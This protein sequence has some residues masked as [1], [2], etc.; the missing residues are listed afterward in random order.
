MYDLNGTACSIFHQQIIQWGVERITGGGGGGRAARRREHQAHG[1][2]WVP[3]QLD[4]HVAGLTSGVPTR[5]FA[6]DSAGGCGHVSIRE[7]GRWIVG[8][9]GACIPDAATQLAQGGGNGQ[10]SPTSFQSQDAIMGQ[11]GAGMAALRI[12][13]QRLACLPGMVL[14]TDDVCYNKRDITNKERKWPKGRAPLLTGGDR[15]CITKAARAAKAIQRTEKQL[16]KLGMLKRPTRR[17]APKAPAYRQIAPGP[18]IINV[19]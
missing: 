2:S 10:T 6:P 16:Q 11:Y 18:S 14:G 3:G 8:P 15:N 19:E 5:T 4:A 13:T 12:Q 1:H 9:A 17:A 7:G